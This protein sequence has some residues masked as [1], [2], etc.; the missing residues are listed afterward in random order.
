MTLSQ[1][2][3]LKRQCQTLSPLK[4]YNTVTCRSTG[5]T[6]FNLLKTTTTQNRR[7]YDVLCRVA[8][9][10]ELNICIM[11]LFF[12][13]ELIGKRDRRKLRVIRWEK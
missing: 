3:K 6:W 13:H 12:F 5:R 1:I 4:V 9:P 7:V 11:F 10:G 8:D 2:T